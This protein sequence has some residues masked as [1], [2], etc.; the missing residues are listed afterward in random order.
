ML[1]AAMQKAGTVDDVGKIRAALLSLTY[2]GLWTIKFD[3]RGEQIF[4][5]DIVH[6]KKGGG[7]EITHVQP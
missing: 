4:N 1:V 5:F 6:L 2:N 7:I 3:Q